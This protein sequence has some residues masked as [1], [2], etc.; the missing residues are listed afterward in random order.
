VHAVHAAAELDA[1]LARVI[2]ECLQCAPGAVAATKALMA[3]ARVVPAASLVQDAS[4]VF[5][6]A[7]LGPEGVEGA[8]A[9]VQKR[10]PKWAPQ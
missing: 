6:R 9:F 1:A 2:D 3:K 4:L 7:A 10:K 5:A 8:S